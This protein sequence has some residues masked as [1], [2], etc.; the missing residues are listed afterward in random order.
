MYSLKLRLFAFALLFSFS[1]AA[2]AQVTN[3][4]VF[5]LVEVVDQHGFERPMPAFSLLAPKDWTVEG[6]IQWAPDLNCLINP[7]VVRL[8]VRAPEGPTQLELF[9]RLI[10]AWSD[11]PYLQQQYQMTQ[12]RPGTL[13]G[14]L[15][16]GPPMDA[17]TFANRV[18]L[19]RER[20]QTTGLQVTGIQPT[21][22]AARAFEARLHAELDRMGF[23]REL[24]SM[25]QTSFDA[26]EIA[27]SQTV[28]GV[29]VEERFYVTVAAIQSSSGPG[30][31][32]TIISSVEEAY[33][34]R[35]PA[36]EPEQIRILK[37][38]IGSIALNRQW[39]D[40]LQRFVS[41]VTQRQQ[42]ALTQIAM[43]NIRTAREV[44]GIIDATIRSRQATWENLAE[45][46]ARV[47]REVTEY[48]DPH[49]SEPI[50][51]DM[52]YNYA[53]SRGDGTYMLTADPNFDPSVELRETG[54]LR[55]ERSN[56]NP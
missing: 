49:T 55:M 21:P 54:W 12:A 25:M 24:R 26:A 5:R 47:M 46:H 22:D 45:M 11:S 40:R 48:V 8:K 2:P 20:G 16:P 10:W 17:A 15:P 38:I 9:P 7:I 34:W 28:D 36:E 33:A 39:T 37:T 43:D 1:E 56:R 13:T 32:S 27:T 50:E 53:W 42:A 35:V 18:L 51:L 31:P 3:G 6:G 52:H 30:M 29:S 19:P 41:D 4:A 44:A 23:P 14:C